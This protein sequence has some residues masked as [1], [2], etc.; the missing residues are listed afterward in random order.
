[1]IDGFERRKQHTSLPDFESRIEVL[2]QQGRLRMC[3]EVKIELQRNNLVR[4]WLKVQPDIVVPFDTLQ[5]QVV[6]DITSRFPDFVDVITGDNAADPF[7]IALAK[8]RRWIVVTEEKSGSPAHP[9]I[10]HICNA[11]TP[12]VDCIKLERLMQLEGWLD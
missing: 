4:P 9:K 2:V 3:E 10:P 8:C 11:F 1:M 5:Q 6:I 7:L 12:P